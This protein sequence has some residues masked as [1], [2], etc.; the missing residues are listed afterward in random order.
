MKKNETQSVRE[1][2]ILQQVMKE[3]EYQRFWNRTMNRIDK[4]KYEKTDK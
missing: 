1:K 3:V 4:L 2:K